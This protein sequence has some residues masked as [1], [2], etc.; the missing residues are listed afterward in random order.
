MTSKLSL[1][2]WERVGAKRRVRVE[3]T[4]YGLPS[5]PS[6]SDGKTEPKMDPVRACGCGTS[7]GGNLSDTAIEMASVARIT[8]ERKQ[9]GNVVKIDDN[10][11]D[12]HE[13]RI[14]DRPY[15]K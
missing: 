9:S 11:F 10:H 13:V 3:V 4:P 12:A 14:T 6:R 5:S 1:S 8:G 7:L 15:F 2:L